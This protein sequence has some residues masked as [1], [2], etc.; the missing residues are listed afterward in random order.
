MQDKYRAFKLKHPK[1]NFV[2]TI[3][4]VESL[5]SKTENNFIVF[6]DVLTNLISDK[7]LNDY[8]SKFFIHR[9]HHSNIV[10]ALLIQNLFPQHCRNIS[11]NA[12]YIIIFKQIRDKTSCRIISQQLKPKFPNFIP[13]A[14]ELATKGKRGSF[15]V[16]DLH[17]DTPDEFRFRNFIWPTDDMHFYF[18][19]K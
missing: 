3:D 18:A 16:V 10:C 8:I 17:H 14:L 13:E 9:V 1:V 6:D 15:I 2:E 19:A 12:T 5:I 4:Q 7:K 11:L